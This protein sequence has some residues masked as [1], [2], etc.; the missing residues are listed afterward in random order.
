VDT[1]LVA[2]PVPTFDAN[3]AERSLPMGV[4][5]RLPV[6]PQSQLASLLDRFCQ[7]IVS[8]H[9]LFPATALGY[10]GKLGRFFDWLEGQGVQTV[11]EITYA[12]FEDFM[13]ESKWP[14]SATS[15]KFACQ[16]RKFARWCKAR[17]VLP[18]EGKGGFTGEFRA[19]KA[20][21]G[22]PKS[23]PREDLVKLLDGARV[24]KVVSG[25]VT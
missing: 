25:E 18:S 5:V 11:A 1:A 14:S 17:G 16:C 15:H 23:I 3:L 12:H 4:I 21:R 9:H 10:R 13:S 6:R 19:P 22:K 8:A 24:S 7:T 20:P 2:P